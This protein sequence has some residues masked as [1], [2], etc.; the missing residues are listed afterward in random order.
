MITFYV[1]ELTP[2]LKD[3]VTGDFVDTEV[4]RLKRKSFLSKFNK[5]TG[6][7]V[8]WSKMPDDVEIYALVIKGTTDIQGLIAVKDDIGAN[9]AY[10]H[11]ACTAPHNN[12]WEYNTQRYKG[13]GGH[14]LA[15]AAKKS[16]EWKHEGVFH[17]DAIDRE[18]LAHYVKEF[19]AWDMPL[20]GHPLHFIVEENVAQNLMEVY[21]YEWTDDEV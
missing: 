17:A 12:I 8:N 4:I 18:V 13:V 16:L 21:T 14:L 10:V 2:C 19:D 3:V 7:Y 11:W 9:A 20:L 1:D 15:I 5:K 6:W